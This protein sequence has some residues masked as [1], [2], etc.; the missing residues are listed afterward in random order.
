[1]YTLKNVPEMN[2]I[3]PFNNNFEYID[4]DEKLTQ[5]CDLIRGDEFIAL[6]TEFV[7][8][9]TYFPQCC[10]IQFASSSCAGIID[11][12]LV[13]LKPFL[14]TIN[15]FTKI[16]HDA[17]QDVECLKQF[18]DFSTNDIFDTQLAELF[19]GYYESKP[20]YKSL[21]SKYFN[22]QIDK[23][24]TTADWSKRPLE[25]NLLKYAIND[26][27][28]LKDIYTIQK[29]KLTELGRFE[30]YKDLMFLETNNFQR[31]EEPTIS[32]LKDALLNWRKNVAKS[33]N[34]PLNFVLNSN[35]I[36]ELAKREPVTLEEFYSS[37]SPSLIKTNE[38]KA[39]EI[40][41]II[42]EYKG[43]KKGQN[44]SHKKSKIVELL[45]IVLNICCLS[46]NIS[47]Y[48]IATIADLTLFTETKQP[49]EDAP[50]LSKE[51]FWN[52]AHKLLNGQISITIK[53]NDIVL[54]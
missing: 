21:V 44:T 8:N 23:A 40:I 37:R 27:I 25:K 18:Y 11:P 2:K 42:E 31:D 28:Y 17:K 22:V 4:S 48:V 6:D 35:L 36:N 3:Y 10:L 7:R 33:K 50:N 47:P 9:N 5:I 32:S 53:N 49:P 38:Q 51:V 45:K 52:Q 54:I 12:L 19:L 34:I 39:R 46:N 41:Q 1:M 16:F 15:N 29:D 43:T 30:T 26:V 24:L 14:E 20:A 13:D